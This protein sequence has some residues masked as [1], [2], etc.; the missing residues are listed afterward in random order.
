MAQ[1]WAQ[2]ARCG[3][4]G[5][6]TVID[7]WCL[8]SLAPSLQTF[9]SVAC[10][11]GVG[12][13]RPSAARPPV[14]RALLRCLLLHYPPKLVRELAAPPNWEKEHKD[15]DHVAWLTNETVQ[16]RAAAV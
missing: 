12:S 14:I 16:V 4:P 13:D 15:D 7:V 6:P 5:A 10:L 3:R 8:L 1:G 9:G 2:P 11:W